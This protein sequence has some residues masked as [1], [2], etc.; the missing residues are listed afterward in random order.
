MKGGVIQLYSLSSL[1]SSGQHSDIKVR[2][3]S[4]IP[5]APP[6]TL[7]ISS[8]HLSV[9]A[10]PARIL[11][12][13]YYGELNIHLHNSRRLRLEFVRAGC[14]DIPELSP[15]CFVKTSVFQPDQGWPRTCLVW[16]KLSREE[17]EEEG[18]LGSI[19][20]YLH[21]SG[22]C[23]LLQVRIFLTLSALDYNCCC[24]FVRTRLTTWSSCS[25]IPT[26]QPFWGSWTK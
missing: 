15:V 25:T 3:P 23:L 24:C 13:N 4:I 5:Q 8:S 10:L 2:T 19:L 21:H 18:T 6:L 12:R 20:S 7:L 16:T 1:P 26:S 11:E 17:E 22:K 9:S 14:D